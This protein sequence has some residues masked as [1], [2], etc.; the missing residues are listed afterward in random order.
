M[1]PATGSNLLSHDAG[2]APVLFVEKSNV[3][4]A[5]SVRKSLRE[6]RFLDTSLGESEGPSPQPFLG[7]VLPTRTSPGLGHVLCQYT[8]TDWLILKKKVT[9]N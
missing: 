4:S 8:N 7:V 9:D 2:R 3:R 5:T 1:T 6:H